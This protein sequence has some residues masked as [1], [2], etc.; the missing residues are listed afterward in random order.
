MK[1]HHHVAIRLRK[2]DDPKWVERRVK[3]FLQYTYESLRRQTMT[4]FLVWLQMDPYGEKILT[5]PSG[6]PE[7]FV[8]TGEDYDCI[9]SRIPK[10]CDWVYST[11]I[12]SDDVYRA[13][14]LALARDV[15]PGKGV[16]CSMFCTGYTHDVH[17]GRWGNYTVRST[18]FHTLMLPVSVYRDSAAMQSVQRRHGA[19]RDTYPTTLLP[20]DRFCAL[21]HGCNT[22]TDER[23]KKSLGARG[24]PFPTTT[25][26]HHPC[27]GKTLDDFIEGRF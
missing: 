14:A 26:R 22:Q 3:I 25:P 21:R 17:T 4:D 18:P 20:L 2:A 24:I 11:R 9:L 5:L 1:I 13:D 12:D 6:G 15:L 7:V 19:I 16:T 8:S 27:K 10:D 23:L